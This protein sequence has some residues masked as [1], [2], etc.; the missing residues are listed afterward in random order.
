MAIF[1][2]NGVDIIYEVRGSGPRLVFHPGTLSDLRVPPTIFDSPLAKHFEILSFDPRGIGQ[3]NSPDASPEMSDYADDLQRLLIHLGWQSALF[4]GE[5]FGGMVLQEFALRY[6]QLVQKLVL[7]VTSSG[8]IGGASFPLH[9]YDIESMTTNEKV[10]FWICSGDRRMSSPD[11]IHTLPELYIPLSNYY[12][13]VC[14]IS[15][16]KNEGALCRLRQ[17]KARMGHDTYE[18]LPG[19]NRETLIC[20]GRYD[21]I[22]P[23]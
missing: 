7:V 18:R 4:I 1:S 8:G 11:D 17:L 2:C 5:S 20:G 3:S 14:E 10:D 21:N 23:F 22:A 9:E 12:S 6:P 19:L 13:K 16:N 15:E